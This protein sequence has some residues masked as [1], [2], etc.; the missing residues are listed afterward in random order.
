MRPRPWTI[1]R[2]GRLVVEIVDG[3]GATVLR[4][5]SRVGVSRAHNY[6]ENMDLARLIVGAQE[7]RTCVEMAWANLDATLHGRSPV[8]AEIAL[9]N[10][11]RKALDSL[12]RR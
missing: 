9:A 7:L 8:V 10:K 12:E 11:M 2:G 5:G 3:D 1:K 4:L 6:H